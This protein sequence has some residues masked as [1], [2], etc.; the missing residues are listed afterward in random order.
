MAFDFLPLL[1][2]FFSTSRLSDIFFVSVVWLAATPF[3]FC[4][5]DAVKFG[6]EKI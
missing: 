3:G 1:D 6:C 4:V 2:V 5:S